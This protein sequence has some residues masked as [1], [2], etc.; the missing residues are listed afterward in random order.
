MGG[1]YL[2]QSIKLKLADQTQLSIMVV[3]PCSI[4][5]FI[6]MGAIKL[7]TLNTGFWYLLTIANVFG[8]IHIP[9]ANVCYGHGTNI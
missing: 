5:A 2:M 9:E 7:I 4:S 8:S 3:I 1:Y 6:I